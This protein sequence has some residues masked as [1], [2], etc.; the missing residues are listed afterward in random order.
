MSNL[1]H[2]IAENLRYF[3]KARGYT[4]QDLGAIVDMDSGHISRVE[5]GVVSI[6]TDLIEKISRALKIEPH[7][8][9]Q[10]RTSKQV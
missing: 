9:L 8:L 5:R 4:Q 2:T 3:R 7:E 1:R 10:K 6:G